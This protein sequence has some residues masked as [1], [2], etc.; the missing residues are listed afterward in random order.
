MTT[1][2]AGILESVTRYER[3]SGRKLPDNSFYKSIVLDIMRKY[4]ESKKWQPGN[5]K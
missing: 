5:T 1:L 3:E 2:E 4:K